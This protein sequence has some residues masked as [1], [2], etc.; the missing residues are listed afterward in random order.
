MYNFK[1]RQAIKP[2]IPS[3]QSAYERDGVKAIRK[4]GFSIQ[5]YLRVTVEFCP[6]ATGI[7]HYERN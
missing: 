5:R 4:K 3:L 2:G 6:A 7:W 1:E